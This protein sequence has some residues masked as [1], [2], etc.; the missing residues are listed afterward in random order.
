MLVISLGGFLG[1]RHKLCELLLFNDPLFECQLQKV[2]DFA[3]IGW[4]RRQHIHLVFPL[5]HNFEGGDE[6][7][8][9]PVDLERHDFVVAF[10]PQH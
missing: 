5:N 9:L 2:D 7:H 1:K 4:R 3:A 6:L 8:G 10:G